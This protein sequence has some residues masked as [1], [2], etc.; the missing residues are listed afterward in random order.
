MEGMTF[1]SKS[2]SVS[3]VLTFGLANRG[4]LFLSSGIACTEPRLSG[5]YS[6]GA[7]F[8]ST[9]CHSS[10]GQSEFDPMHATLLMIEDDSG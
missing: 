5:P 10:G 1:S 4:P 8:F 7:E 3:L 6:Y 9:E 2:E